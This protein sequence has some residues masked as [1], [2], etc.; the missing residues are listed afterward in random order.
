MKL[1]RLQSESNITQTTFTNN[2]AVNLTIKE[3][4]KVALSNISVQFPEPSLIV[5]ND[6]NTF[7]FHTGSNIDDLDIEV[8]IPNGNYTITSLKETLSLLMNNNLYTF[9]N[10][11]LMTTNNLNFEWL[12]TAEGD[13]TLGYKLSMGFN[14]TDPL[15]DLTVNDVTLAGMTVSTNPLKFYKNTADD[16]GKFNA[17]LYGDTLLCRG[18]WQTSFRVKEQVE[19]QAQ[20]IEDSEWFFY[21]SKNKKTGGTSDR[22]DIVFGMIAGF[23][24][25]DK[26]YYYKKNG[27]MVGSNIDIEKD[28]VVQI[29]KG[30][31]G[32]IRYL[33][34]SNGGA[35]IKGSFQGD[36]VN[37]LAQKLGLADMTTFIKV[38]NNTGKIAFENIGYTP[39]PY[40]T[41]ID[42][43]LTKDVL[44]QEVKQNF[45]INAQPTD[46]ALF[47]PTEGIR[48]FLGYRDPSYELN[49]LS[50][51]FEA[52]NAISST[53]FN[54]DLVIEILEFPIQAYDH[55]T[56][57][58]R[59]IIAVIT[60]GEIQASVR[61]KGVEAFEV[62]YISQFPLFF[63]VG[64][65]SSTLT[66][67]SLSLRMTSQGQLLRCAGA[68]T[69]T[70]LIDE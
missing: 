52:D 63:S 40:Q 56:R 54:N 38:G 5:S 18:G 46:V 20:K 28:D 37:S 1:L 31:D 21:I 39:S 12:V 68:I 41:V 43:I 34:F 24:G 11:A 42:G 32:C 6:N 57:K 66:F 14:R 3:G 65:P 45:N 13:A 7:E 23:E 59:P 50:G 55:G 25:F 17:E 49:A 51:T 22:N 36:N 64:N 47:F 70:I 15:T 69:A 16:N 35:D 67:S 29:E 48:F 58:N 8:V 4:S 2:L 10:T 61:G 27:D 26:Q 30:V 62:S 60:S 53:F 44:T 9:N 33:I 19:G